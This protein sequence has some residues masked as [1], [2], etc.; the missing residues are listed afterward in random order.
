[1]NLLVLGGSQ[2]VG[3]HIV[4]AALERGHTVTT[5]TRGKTPDGLPERV[6]RLHGDRDGQLDA[7]QT[8]T[9]DACIDVSGYLPRVVR[10]SAEMLHGRVGRYLFISTVS[11]YAPSERET[12]TEDSPL[13]EL[14]DPATEDVRAHYGGLKVLCERLISGLYGDRATHVRPH[15]VA[16]PD[17]HTRRFTYWPEALASQAEVLAPG[18]GSDPVQYIDARDLAAFVV[19]LLEQD[20]GGTFHTA[21]PSMSWHAFLNGVAEALRSQAELVWTPVGELEA[22]GLGWN[23]LPLFVPRV[24]DDTALMRVD[25]AHATSAGLSCRP[26]AETARDTLAWSLTL[27][28]DGRPSVVPAR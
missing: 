14:E 23:E 8:G 22:R 24:Q 21:A 15:I 12:T 4:L 5:F 9:W 20:T 7:L 2:F 26:L 27:P 10:Q 11:V 17:D 25:N 3:R 28:A 13:I 18:D 16:G 6:T 19:H 1:M